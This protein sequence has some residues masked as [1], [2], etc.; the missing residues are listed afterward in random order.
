MG[1][2]K[3]S[4]SQRLWLGASLGWEASVAASIVPAESMLIVLSK[5][6]LQA[7]ARG[8]LWTLFQQAHCPLRSCQLN[9]PRRN[10]DSEG[11]G[12]GVS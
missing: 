7:L 8:K 3:A 9:G 10:R 6:G 12:Q 4:H 11:R 2:K 5:V 1:K